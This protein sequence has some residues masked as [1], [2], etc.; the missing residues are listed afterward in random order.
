MKLRDR[1]MLKLNSVTAGLLTVHVYSYYNSYFE[2][3]KNIN[4]VVP[5][6]I[7]FIFN[8]VYCILN[9]IFYGPGDAI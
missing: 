1:L 7:F 3:L 5:K 2:I 8:K 9:K 4:S 6:R